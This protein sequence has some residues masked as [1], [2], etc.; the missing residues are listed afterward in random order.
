MQS[1]LLVEATSGQSKPVET[2]RCPT[3]SQEVEASAEEC[4]GCGRW[5]EPLSEAGPEAAAPPHP[6]AGVV[7]REELVS[8]E[9][10]EDKECPWENRE[11]YGTL[12]A[13][14]QTATKLLMTPTSFFSRLPTS[15]G[16]LNPIL[17]ACMSFP[18]AIVLTYFWIAYFLGFHFSGFLYALIL[19][20]CT[21]V[22]ALV[23]VPIGLAIWSGLFHLCLYFMVALAKDMRQPSVFVSYSS[24]TAVLMAIPFVGIL[25]AGPWSLVLN[26]IGLRETHK[27]TTAKAAAAVAIP[28][29]VF[30]LLQ[31]A[32]GFS[33]LAKLGLLGGS[34]IQ[35]KHAKL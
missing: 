7:S 5:L 33:N 6:A 18:V 35:S 10:E 31:L 4:P 15:G 16:F 27:T 24:V 19:M 17:F 14:F 13:Y 21:F 23:S 9:I 22:A 12:N 26:V 8:D 29:V 34:S 20:S 32:T 25:A 3:C 1:G 11:S 2:R 30:L 28:V